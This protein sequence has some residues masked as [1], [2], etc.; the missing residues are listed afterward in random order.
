[1]KYEAAK[2]MM[3]LGMKVTHRVWGYR[4]VYLYMEGNQLKVMHRSGKVLNLAPNAFSDIYKD[5]WKPYD[6]PTS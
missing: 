2:L 1:M 3:Q 4:R 6:I 5:G